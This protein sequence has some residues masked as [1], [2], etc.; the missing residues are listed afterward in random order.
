[1]RA[2]LDALHR[3]RHA[4]HRRNPDGVRQDGGVRGAR[5]LLAH[6][7]DDVF[8]VELDGE[9]GTELL[10]HYD[11]RLGDRLPQLVRAAVH[12]VLDHADRHSG[13]V[14]EAI[15]EARAAGRRPC[16]AYFERLEL[17]GL[18]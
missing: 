3:T 5:A 12:E 15:L 4:E 14:G 7:P 9:S 11:G 8:A 1:G 18:L 13:E 6:E 10:R 17:E 16:V 2:R